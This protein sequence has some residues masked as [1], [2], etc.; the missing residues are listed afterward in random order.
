MPWG[1]LSE[2]S[3][4]LAILKA[5]LEKKNITST[6]YHA[7]IFILRYITAET[8][9]FISRMW[10]I[11][12]FVFTKI[13]DDEEIDTIQD[14]Y[15]ID[16]S[17]KGSIDLE[18]SV[19]R[20]KEDIYK[21]ILQ[22]RNKVIPLYL[23]ECADE[24]L[25]KQPTMVG[26]TCMFD[27]TLA[28]VALAKI[29]KLKKPEIKI[30]FGGYAISNPVGANLLKTFPYIDAIVEG[31][32]EVIIEKL[33]N[34]SVGNCQL[35]SIP[36]VLTRSE[37][38]IKKNMPLPTIDL[39]KSS[40]PNFLDWFLNISSLKENDKVTVK[41]S[42]LPVEASRGCWWGEHNHCV[43]CGI[44]DETLKFR[45]KSPENFFL[46]LETLS[47][48]YKENK[49]R[50]SDYILPKQYYKD[51]LITLAKKEPRYE[52]MSEIKANQS[53][54]R[55]SLLSN[56]GYVE[57]QP[58]IESFSSEVLKLMNKGVT[59]IENILTIKGGYLYKIIINYN[60]LYGIPKE[61]PEWYLSMLEQMPNLYHLLPPTNRT[62]TVIT[63]YAPL[64]NNLSGKPKHH[65]SYNVLFSKK[66]L[67]KTGFS[68]DDFAYYFERTFDYKKELKTLYS[69]LVAQIDHWKE[70]HRQRD[71]YL[72]YSINSKEIKFYDTRFNK[73]ENTFKLRGTAKEIYLLCNEKIISIKNVYEELSKIGVHNKSEI[74]N[75]I[76]M[77]DNKRLIWKEKNK[78][79]GLAIPI[80]TF[81]KYNNQSWIK[82]WSSIYS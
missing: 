31:D 70:Q 12:E 13:I 26:F 40:I 62:E 49:F 73:V 42:V 10:G 2:P 11:N 1:A 39:N 38:G 8:Y 46:M 81:K 43:F 37:I 75:A 47:D 60:I 56:A 29:I 80:D 74:N 17:I 71:V 79:L 65:H 6:V 20:T 22:L 9:D 4:G 82:S 19:Y 32:G 69:M 44:D 34:S 36:G 76:T 14:K 33:A 5:S 66:F 41:T 16:F 68:Y 61:K 78:I 23:Q 54:E 59:G 52:I 21:L 53:L 55:L 27:Q 30:V 35:N 45:F 67:E 50:F 63:R 57:V 15:I 25:K 77:L 28:S 7:N 64:Y 51:V 58:G 72:N 3:L 24:I 18:H 48:T